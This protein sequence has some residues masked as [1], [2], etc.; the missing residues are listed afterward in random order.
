M[1]TISS[2]RLAKKSNREGASPFCWDETISHPKTVWSQHPLHLLIFERLATHRLNR[3]QPPSQRSPLRQAPHPDVPRNLCQ[4]VLDAYRKLQLVSA[5]GS[6]T[7][8]E[9]RPAADR[10]EA[11]ER[12]E[13]QA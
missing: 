4:R 5:V 9:H 2:G 10:V 3:W 6:K 7:H 13:D 8:E 11:L 12:C 1:A